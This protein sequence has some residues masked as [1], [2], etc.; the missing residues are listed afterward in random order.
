MTLLIFLTANW[1]FIFDGIEEYYYDFNRDRANPL[2]VLGF[3]NLNGIVAVMI[4]LIF[5]VLLLFMIGAVVAARRVAKI[6]KF[7]LV[8]TQQPPELS[9]VLGLTWHLFNSHI[10]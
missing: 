7:R 3:N 9:I 8:S 5:S 2:N 10:W 1:I 4:S 6:P